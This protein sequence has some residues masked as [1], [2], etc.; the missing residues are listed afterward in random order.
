TVVGPEG[1]ERPV[2]DRDQGVIRG[3]GGQAGTARYLHLVSP[4]RCRQVVDQAVQGA[5]RT[6]G[7]QRT[8]GERINA[9]GVQGQ[10]HLGLADNGVAGGG[11]QGQVLARSG[12]NGVDVR[13]VR[14][15]VGRRGQARGQGVGPL[16]AVVG[17]D[18]DDVGPRGREREALDLGVR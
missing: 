3:A 5:A 9:R 6:G 15:R 14:A 16:L 2:R 13:A 10:L 4:R 1:V 8:A 17:A 7:G 12:R 11:G 18:R